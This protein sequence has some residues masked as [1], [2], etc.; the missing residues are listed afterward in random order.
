MPFGGVHPIIADVELLDACHARTLGICLEQGG[1][2]VA[3]D[4]PI[5]LRNLTLFT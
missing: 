3:S 2:V 1:G 5:A 4:T